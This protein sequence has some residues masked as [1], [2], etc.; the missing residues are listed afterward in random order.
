M[1]LGVY[2]FVSAEMSRERHV[3]ARRFLAE[4]IEPRHRR[5][6]IRRMRLD[7]VPDR[8]AA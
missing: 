5:A 2:P 4:D 8:E 6:A 3:I 7:A 1:S